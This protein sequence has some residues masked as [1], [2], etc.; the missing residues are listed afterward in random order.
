MLYNPAE[1]CRLGNYF[2]KSFSLS[3]P[4]KTNGIL[5]GKAKTGEFVLQSEASTLSVACNG[6]FFFGK[7]ASLAPIE[8]ECTVALCEI[9]GEAAAKMSENGAHLINPL[10][11]P[12]TA[13]LFRLLC[14]KALEENS[15]P[16]SA[17][18]FALLCALFE[19][20]DKQE[21]R[22]PA[23]AARA[24]VEMRENYCKI[25]GVEEL[26]ESL[27]VSK[28]HLI[29]VFSAATGK[30]PGQYLT[31]VRIAAAKRLLLNPDYTLEITAGLCGF[32]GANYLC[33]VFKR[34]TGLTPAQYRRIAGDSDYI[35]LPQEKPIYV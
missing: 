28:S 10:T 6:M 19:A 26:S 8:G 35:P 24:I 3:L 33:R 23:L 5:V 13:G 7:E 32:S 9:S 18:A 4:L 11:H 27:G 17:E 12:R 31:E 1:T 15:G 25:Y 20:E 29:R 14:E 30:S 22:L 2:E 21:A 34:C 16:H